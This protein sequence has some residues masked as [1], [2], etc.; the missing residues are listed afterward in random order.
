MFIDQANI[1]LWPADHEIRV[2]RTALA[3][4]PPRLLPRPLP[5]PLE[6]Y[7]SPRASF[8]GRFPFLRQRRCTRERTRRRVDVGVLGRRCGA[9]ES[10]T[11]PRADGGGRSG[12][13]PE[14]LLVAQSATGACRTK[15][16]CR[17]SRAAESGVRKN[18]R[19]D[20]RRRKWTD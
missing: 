10:T 18:H 8:L 17:R 11:S 3:I 5:P 7:I 2:T 14:R 1:P 12:G 4:T 19:G 13:R 16:C 15:T 20:F 6:V 9:Q